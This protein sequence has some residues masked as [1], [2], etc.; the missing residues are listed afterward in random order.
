MNRT[1]KGSFLSGRL[2]LFTAKP[3]KMDKA[4]ARKSGSSALSKGRKSTARANVNP[5]QAAEIEFDAECA[6]DA[7]KQITGKRFL[8]RDIPPIPVPDCDSPNCSCSYARYRDRRQ[9]IDD[10]RGLFHASTNAYALGDEPNRRKQ[11]DRRTSE[12]SRERDLG[13]IDDFESWFVD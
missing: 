4:R 1:S 3:K 2:G 6:C 10:R 11:R 12:E 8:V 5:Y 9:W 7:V 13:S